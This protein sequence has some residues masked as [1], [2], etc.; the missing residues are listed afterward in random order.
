MSLSESR[1][2]HSLSKFT[3][4]RSGQVRRVSATSAGAEERAWKTSVWRLTDL[5]WEIS[6]VL[7]VRT[8]SLILTP[9]NIT[10]R[11]TWGKLV[12]GVKNEKHRSAEPIPK[13]SEPKPALLVCLDAYLEPDVRLR[14]QVCWVLLDR[15]IIGI[16]HPEVRLSSRTRIGT[17]LSS[18]IRSFIVKAEILFCN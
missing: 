3:I 8:M 7:A 9:L 18:T 1:N 16:N 10:T 14:S 13:L 11:S 2:L 15:M 6:M 12:W 4:R 5:F 17:Q